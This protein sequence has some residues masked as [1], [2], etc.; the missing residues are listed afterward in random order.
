MRDGGEEKEEVID[1]LWR[2]KLIFT[3]ELKWSNGT[4]HDRNILICDPDVLEVVRRKE[5]V[6]EAG[7][8]ALAGI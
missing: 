6:V 3:H 5:S 1:R 8:R 4:D 7:F 2:L